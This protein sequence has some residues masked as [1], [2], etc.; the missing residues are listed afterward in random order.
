MLALHRAGM[1]C[2][3]LRHDSWTGSPQPV[4]WEGTSAAGSAVAVGPGVAGDVPWPVGAVPDGV[5]G[6]PEGAPV[7]GAAAVAPEGPAVA[8]SE[9]LGATAAAGAPPA[10]ASAAGFGARSRQGSADWLYS[11]A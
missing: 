9:V 1:R 11:A 2:R 8:S 4:C 10:A 5:A 6:P 7:D 3:P